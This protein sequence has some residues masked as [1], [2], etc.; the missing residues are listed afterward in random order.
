MEFK[1]N[2]E[3]RG[4]VTSETSWRPFGINS[5]EEIAE[6]DAL[7]DGI[8][9]WMYLALWEWIKKKIEDNFTLF[10]EKSN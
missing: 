8:L 6:Y 9:G 4:K 2:V 1:F 7:H 5:D 10:I 3:G